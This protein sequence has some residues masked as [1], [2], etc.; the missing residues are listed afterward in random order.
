MVVVLFLLILC[1]LSL[2][3]FV[4]VLIQVHDM[5]CRTKFS[6]LVLESV[7]LGELVALH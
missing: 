7:L 2:P 3:M 5:F 1:L 4:G 6:F